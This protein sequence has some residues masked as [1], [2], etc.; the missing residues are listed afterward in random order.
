MK[1]GPV[2]S[3]LWQRCTW[4]QWTDARERGNVPML[5]SIATVLQGKR[6]GMVH[7]LNG[8]EIDT[9]KRETAECDIT[10]VRR[11][12]FFSDGAKCEFLFTVGDP[13]WRRRR[14]LSFCRWDKR[15]FGRRRTRRIVKIRLRSI[16]VIRVSAFNRSS[17]LLRKIKRKK[18]F[19]STVCGCCINHRALFAWSSDCVR[20]ARIN[21]LSKKIPLHRRIFRFTVGKRT[22]NENETMIKRGK[23]MYFNHDDRRVIVK[24]GT[25]PHGTTSPD[26]PT[27]MTNRFDAFWQRGPV[28]LTFLSA[29]CTAAM[30]VHARFHSA[31]RSC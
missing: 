26:R 11:V 6:P 16:P 30:R 1:R 24:S 19:E 20:V 25:N 23:K 28:C 10:G 8:N 9:R 29:A 14:T 3:P 27:P 4:H 17:E 12:L 5:T 18:K 2:P 22:I 15:R 21:Y 31:W 13:R 7:S